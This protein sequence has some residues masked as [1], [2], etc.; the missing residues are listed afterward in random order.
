M[1]LESMAGKI[2]A[3]SGEI[4]ETKPFLPFA[5]DDCVKYF[6]EQLL[7]HGYNYFGNEVMYSGTYGEIMKVDIFQGVVYY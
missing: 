2:G 1:L 3:L 6:G 5:D 7:K 4:I